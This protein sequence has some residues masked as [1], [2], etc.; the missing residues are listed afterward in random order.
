[1]VVF[2]ETNVRDMGVLRQNGLVWIGGKIYRLASMAVLI[3]WI[4][5]VNLLSVIRTLEFI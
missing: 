2:A 1:M 5:D 4:I 3:I